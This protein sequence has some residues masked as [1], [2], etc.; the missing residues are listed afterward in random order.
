M[1]KKIIVFVVLLCMM[2]GVHIYTKPKGSIPILGYH[3]VVK[4]DEKKTVYRNDAY[5]LSESQFLKQMDYLKNK[6]YRT[7]SMDELDAF[8]EQGI[9][10]GKKLVCLTFDDG[11]KNF[12][13]VV[14]PIMEEYGFKATCFVIGKHLED[15]NDAFLKLDECI[16]TENVAYY[17][18]S[19]NLHRKGYNFD[20]KIIETMTMDEIDNDFKQFPLDSSYFAFPYGRSVK[21]IGNVLEQNNVKLA[22]LYNQFHDMTSKDSR[23]ALPR[24][25]ICSYT[26][27]CLY[28]YIVS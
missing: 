23:Y 27:Y 15:S 20:Q 8:Y 13:T 10:F 2:V 26:P 21:G 18:H 17:S 7:L 4:D 25:L 6:G 24:Y 3:G 5:I 16:N 11:Y 22:F 19:Y 9:D 12:N 14:K 1:K 28:R